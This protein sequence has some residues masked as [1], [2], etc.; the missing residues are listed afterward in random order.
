[1]LKTKRKLGFFD[2]LMMGLSGAIGFEIFILLDYPYFN[3]ELG[4]GIVFG[5]LLAGL[6]NL[7]IMFNYCELSTAMPEVGGAY[8]YIKAAYAGFISFISGCFRWLASI[9]G[10]ALAA[11]VFIQQISYVLKAALNL[12]SFDLTQPPLIAVIVVIAM[13]ALGVKG[14]KGAGVTIVLAFIAIFAIFVGSGLFHGLAPI[15]VFPKNLPINIPKVFAATVYMFPMFFGVRS[16]V[17]GA[18]QIKHPERNIPKALLLSSLLI[19]PL[20]ICVT[21]TAVGTV[22]LEEAQLMRQEAGWQVPLLNL[23]AQ[24]IFG[25]AGGALIA[26][27]GMVASLSALGTSLTVQASILQGMSRDAY[28]PRLLRSAHQR[29]GTPYVAIIA[30]SLFVM[31]LSVTGAVEFLG[32]GA[33]FGSLLVFAL[34]N[35]SLLK[36]RKKKPHM[37]RPFKTPLYPFTP[38][39]GLIVSI[40]LLLFPMLF[41]E[42]AIALMSCIGLTALVLLAYYFRMIGRHRMQIAIGGAGLSIGIFFVLLT[43]L[44]EAGLMPPIFPFIPSYIML[45]IGAISIIAGILNAVAHG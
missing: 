22:S 10:A 6:V 16:L 1:M 40:A 19:I 11:V 2:A 8:T 34:V 17:A 30:G 31:F 36:L 7:L 20:Y 42:A 39:A 41:P 37:E 14:K 15:E 45:L 13:A 29:F 3:L 23:A 25:W 38:I 44:V 35:L 24:K 33:S 9:F 5:L 4:A 43:C 12:Q 27:A 32:Y 28:L 21:Y 18:A 26:V